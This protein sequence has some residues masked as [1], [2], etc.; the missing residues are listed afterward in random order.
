[1]IDKS[2]VA[3][4]GI[5]ERPP[6]FHPSTTAPRLSVTG[7]ILSYRRCPR[8][9]GHY[10]FRGFAPT[11]A[12][13][14]FVGTFAHKSLSRAVKFYLNTGGAPADDVMA[15]LMAEVRDSLGDE[16][17]RPQ[18]WQAI[19][20]T[21]FQLMRLNRSFA[22]H[23]IY[24]RMVDS[25]RMLRSFEGN[26]VAEGIVDVIQSDGNDVELWDYKATLNP[27]QS[28][29]GGPHEGLASSRIRDYTLQMC[30]YSH[31]HARNFGVKP[32]VCRVLF[33]SEI[34][35]GGLGRVQWAD[36]QAEAIPN[37]AQPDRCPTI[38]LTV[39]TAH[40]PTSQDV[41]REFYET[42]DEILD[43]MRRDHWAYPEVLPGRKTCDSCDFRWS[44]TPASEAFGYFESMQKLQVSSGLPKASFQ[45]YT[46]AKRVVVAMTGV[47]GELY[48]MLRAW[49]NQIAKDNYDLNRLL[50]NAI[51][52]DIALR[53]PR[54]LESLGR[55]RGIGPKLLATYGTT[56]VTMIQ[57]HLKEGLAAR[58]A[59]R[60]E[61][62]PV[63]PH[64]WTALAVNVND[65]LHQAGILF[66]DDF[67]PLSGEEVFDDLGLSPA[68]WLEVRKYLKLTEMEPQDRSCARE[69]IARVDAVHRE[70]R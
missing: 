56:V 5:S 40:D 42:A 44:C 53:Q 43:S 55:T 12:T 61:A 20:R 14:E 66:L 7:D 64:I 29:P 57:T 46:P 49:R 41:L 13:Q 18:Q 50:R 26:F 59:A 51:L 17:A 52:K 62:P 23:G 8:Q 27:S 35:I 28:S 30:V 11:T 38:F 54:T 69:F 19:N 37:F 70:R 58:T 47:S 1:M 24:P 60:E 63:V 2:V 65:R 34:S 33:L 16:G 32:K 68:E 45:E 15:E 3:R 36:Y 48:E 67:W 9:Y 4:L 22:E 10:N 25:E 21:G 39:D 31:L 6:C